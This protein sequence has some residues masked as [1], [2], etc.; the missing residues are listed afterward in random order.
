VGGGLGVLVG[1]ERGS[2]ANVLWRGTLPGSNENRKT[3]EKKQERSHVR[4]TGEGH[5]KFGFEKIIRKMGGEGKKGGRAKRRRLKRNGKNKDNRRKVAGTRK[6][7]DR[8]M[9]P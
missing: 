4:G 8:L 3:G 1:G 9:G 5:A 2:L 7:T 6:R